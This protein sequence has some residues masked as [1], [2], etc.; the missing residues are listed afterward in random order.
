MQYNDLRFHL[1][2]HHRSVFNSLPCSDSSPQTRVQLSKDQSTLPQVISA[3]QPIHFF[4]KLTDAIM[5]FIVKDMQ[6]LNTIDDKGFR[7]MI[8]IFELRYNPLS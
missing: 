2:E 7:H 4:S 5:Y 3:T 6:P 1:R 8:H